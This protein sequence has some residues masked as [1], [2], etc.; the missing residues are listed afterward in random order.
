MPLGIAVCT[1][2]VLVSVALEVDHVVVFFELVQLDVEENP[3]TVGNVGETGWAG[4]RGCAGSEAA[5]WCGGLVLAV[6]GGRGD[7]GDVEAATEFFEVAA[8]VVN[9]GVTGSGSLD[10]FLQEAG[11][12]KPWVFGDIVIGWEVGVFALEGLGFIGRGNCIR[13]DVGACVM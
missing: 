6:F 11:A 2:H 7:T 13:A 1:D 4:G 10:A 5:V 9:A 12:D 3:D 8:T